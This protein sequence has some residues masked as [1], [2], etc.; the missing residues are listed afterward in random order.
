MITVSIAEDLPEIRSTLESI[1]QAEADM[2]LLS[3][4]PT[5]EDAIPLITEAQPDI[6]IMDINL[7]GMNG[8]DCRRRIKNDCPATQFMIFTIYD[9]LRQQLKKQQAILEKERA[10]T[11]ERSRIAADMHRDVGAGLSRI[12]YITAAMRDKLD[13]SDDIDKIVSLSDESVEK[14]NE[15]IWALNQGN[16]QLDELIY[17]TRSQCSEMVSNASSIHFRSAGNNPVDNAQL[18]GLPQYLLTGKRSREQCYQTCR[19]Y[20]YYH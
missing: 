1:I 7:P 8:I 12:R 14:M 19:R 6:V 3:S 18:E 16:Q 15:I 13:K 9:Y 11:E 5:A 4:S 20:C 10:L 17:Y 2:L